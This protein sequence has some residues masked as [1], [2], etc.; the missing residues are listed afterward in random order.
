M[1]KH[2][3]AKIRRGYYNYRGWPVVANPAMHE[4]TVSNEDDSVCFRARTL[5]AMRKQ[6]DRWETNQARR[7]GTDLGGPNQ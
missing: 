6:I 1:S 2:R 5:R 7:L 4:W 3:I